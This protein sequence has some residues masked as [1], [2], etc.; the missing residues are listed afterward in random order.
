MRRPFMHQSGDTLLKEGRQ[1]HLKPCVDT[2]SSSSDSGAA[3][4]EGSK[5]SISYTIISSSKQLK[6]KFWAFHLWHSFTHKSPMTWHS[7]NLSSGCLLTQHKDFLITLQK[8]LSHSGNLCSKFWG[9]CSLWRYIF[10]SLEISLLFYIKFQLHNRLTK[11]RKSR[12]NSCL[13]SLKT[14]N[15][16]L[17]HLIWYCTCRSSQAKILIL[18]LCS[19]N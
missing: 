6:D 12:T 5:E 4:T 7:L 8:H 3:F 13:C 11:P 14:A 15:A 1:P 19:S 17:L 16:F 10:I 18:S 9:F 2:V